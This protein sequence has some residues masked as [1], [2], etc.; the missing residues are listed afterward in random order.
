[1][2]PE[3]V[4]VNRILHE[5]KEMVRIGEFGVGVPLVVQSVAERFGVSV[6]PVRDA[7]NRLV[8]ER[9][10]ILQQGGGFAI[11][12][13]STELAAGLYEWHADLVRMIVEES[14]GYSDILPVPELL[15]NA[16][17]TASEIA[18]LT[19]DLFNQIAV[20]SSNVERRSAIE[21]V[22]DRLHFLRLH[23]GP[24]TKRGA[25][26]HSLWKIVREGNRRRIQLTLGNYH[27]RRIA[28]AEQIAIAATINSWNERKLF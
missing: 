26:L 13:I 17:A 7:L 25:E 1:M 14:E 18:S 2:S 15:R 28:R 19:G 4:T 12:P 22:G 16:E 6:Q 27:R 21:R 8:G 5:L 24:L 10:I 9:F 23:E 20:S 11:P 3:A